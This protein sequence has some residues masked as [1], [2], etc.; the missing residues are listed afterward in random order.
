MKTLDKLLNKVGLV[1]KSEAKEAVRR[2]T[3]S[4]N[5]NAQLAADLV[6]QCQE[7]STQV[8]EFADEN[9]KLREKLAA[10]GAEVARLRQAL[11]EI[12][13]HVDDYLDDDDL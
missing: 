3:E 10:S 11:D 12:R 13:M 7:Y 5:K 9:N 8:D 2:Y 6:T 4:A 1:R